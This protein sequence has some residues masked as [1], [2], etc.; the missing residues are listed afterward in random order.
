MTSQGKINEVFIFY[1]NSHLNQ[2]KI[3]NK[4]FEN[5]K[6]CMVLYNLFVSEV[7]DKDLNQVIEKLAN[8]LAYNNVDN[9]V[10]FLFLL[11]LT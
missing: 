5:I 9:Q 2:N 1:L 4:L 6:A 10:S 11:N 3:K 7:K 8:L